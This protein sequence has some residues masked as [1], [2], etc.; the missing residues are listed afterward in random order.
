MKVRRDTRL[1]IRNFTQDLGPF[2]IHPTV[3]NFEPLALLRVN[4]FSERIVADFSAID[5][6]PSQ[7]SQHLT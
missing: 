2:E 3:L 4:I 7:F 5:I 6:M 1:A